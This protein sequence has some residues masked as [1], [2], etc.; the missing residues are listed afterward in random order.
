MADIFAY[1]FLFSDFLRLFHIFLIIS[2][3][4]GEVLD[5]LGTG[6]CIVWIENHR[7]VVSF[8]NPYGNC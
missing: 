8:Q 7:Y 1:R 5:E 6:N 3:E 2:K 4:A